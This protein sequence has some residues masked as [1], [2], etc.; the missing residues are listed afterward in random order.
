[1]AGRGGILLAGASTRPL[2]SLGPIDDLSSHLRIEGRSLEVKT[3][4]GSLGGEPFGLTGNIDLAVRHPQTGLPRIALRLHGQ[5]LPLARQPGLILRSDLDVAITSQT[6]GQALVS[7]L[8]RVRDSVFLSDLRELIATKAAQ[9]RQRPPFFSL[10][11]EPIA[12]WRLNVQVKG[13][14]FLKVRS[15]FFQ[16]VVSTDLKLEGTLQEPVALG[17]VTVNSGL[18][19]FPFANLEL[20]QG[21]ISLTS[22]DPYRP[23]LFLTAGA[24]AFGYD[25]KMEVTGKSDSPVIQF[26]ST[27]PLSSEQIVLMLTA[28]ELPKQENS[29]SAQQRAGRLALFL[30]KN[31]L[32]EFSSGQGGADRLTIR[33]GEYLSETG[34][35]TYSV[36]YRIN[37]NWSIVGEYDRFG[38]INADLKWRLYSR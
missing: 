14:R 16:G 30:G 10:D 4:S 22:E 20:T 21:L 6:N 7:G 15:P 13:E 27:P 25:V 11:V 36:E 1:M 17:D 26:T 38:A 3:F 24:R 33:S 2:P 23:Q 5:D 35:Q 34:Q 28:G 8:A 9:P 12:D 31:L 29:I 37:K 18:V 32:S 19:Q